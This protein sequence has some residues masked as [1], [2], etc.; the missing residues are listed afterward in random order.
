MTKF[1]KM[2]HKFL[3]PFLWIFMLFSKTTCIHILH[4]VNATFLFGLF[5]QVSKLFFKLNYILE[6]LVVMDSFFMARFLSKEF[7]LKVLPRKAYEHDLIRIYECLKNT[8]RLAQSCCIQT[9]T[10]LEYCWQI[11]DNN[12][13]NKSKK[14]IITKFLQ[15][16]CWWIY[17]YS[18]NSVKE[19]TSF[20]F[21]VFSLTVFF[22]IFAILNLLNHQKNSLHGDTNTEDL[23]Q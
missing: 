14:T 8:L 3:L 6:I 7:L 5:L 20:Q 9:F 22:Y 11:H 17:C 13:Y 18:E 23:Q 10:Y 16:P 1:S 21:C 15:T 4:R 12:R 19:N 2:Y